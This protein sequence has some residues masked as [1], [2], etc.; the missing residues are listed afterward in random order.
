MIVVPSF[1]ERDQRNKPIVPAVIVCGEAAFT[2]NVCE[3]IDGEGAVIKNDSA[4]EESPDQHLE[5]RGSQARS[6]S[7]ERRAQEKR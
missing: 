7:L 5:A 6:V 1:A 2:K 3:R 4:D